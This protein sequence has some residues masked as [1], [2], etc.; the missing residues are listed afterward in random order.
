MIISIMLI[1][2]FNFL[3]PENSF[4]TQWY[5]RFIIKYIQT[6]TQA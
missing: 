6:S 1:V 2:V 3:H 4:V 5:I